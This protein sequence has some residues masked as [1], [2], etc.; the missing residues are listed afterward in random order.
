MTTTM[1]YSSNRVAY[2]YAFAWLEQK[3]LTCDHRDWL[4]REY[5]AL[6]QRDNEHD[7]VSAPDIEDFW[8]NYENE[9]FRSL[10]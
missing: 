1:V 10:Y 9:P 6:A 3:N 8:R 2:H 5:A 7:I 4:A